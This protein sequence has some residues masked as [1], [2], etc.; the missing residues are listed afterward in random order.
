MS[1]AAPGSAVDTAAPPIWWHRLG[2]VTPD[3]ASPARL[4]S[5]APVSRGGCPR[6]RRPHS[7]PGAPPA[8]RPSGGWPEA[9]PHRLSGLRQESPGSP[10]PPPRGQLL[11]VPLRPRPQASPGVVRPLDARGLIVRPKVGFVQ[12]ERVEFPLPPRGVVHLSDVAFCDNELPATEKGPLIHKTHGV[13]R[14]AQPLRTVHVLR[15]DFLREAKHRGLP[16]HG[17]QV[18]SPPTGTEAKEGQVDGQRD[19]PTL[20]AP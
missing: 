17:P 11:G 16:L 3:T 14:P 7:E 20:Q 9:T 8:S 4:P 18:P 1:G 12:D 5:R 19:R 15:G 13:P 10:P 6:Q 2:R